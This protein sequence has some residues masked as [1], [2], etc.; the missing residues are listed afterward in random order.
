MEYNEMPRPQNPR[1]KPKSKFQ[2]FK[3][4]YLPLIIIALTLV[5]AV[6]FIIGGIKQRGDGPS[7]Q[8]PTAPTDLG[9]TAPSTSNSTDPVDPALLAE[10]E[11]LMQQAALLIPEYDYAGALAILDTFS[12]DRNTIPALQEVYAEYTARLADMVEWKGD[13]VQILSIH[14]LIADME[15]AFNDDIYAA[16]YRKNFIT[17]SEFSAILNQLYAN[18]Y[19]LVSLDD[20]YTMEYNPSSG[21]DVYVAKTLLLPPGKTPVLLAETNAN[22]Y[23]YMTDSNGNGKPDGNADGFAYKLCY[24]A[25]NGFYNEMINSEG[26]LVTGAFDIVPMLEDFIAQHP[27]FSYR[28]ARAIIACS[29]YD[30]ILGYR[31]NSTKLTEA[32][33]QVE[34][35]AV[36]EL[37]AQ[38]RATGYQIACFT[39][40]S[41]QKST[42]NYSELS[43][44]EVY[45]DIQRWKEVIEPVIGQVDIMLFPKEVDIAGQEIYD[46]AKFNV[47]YDAGFRFFLSANTTSWDQVHDK[48]VRHSVLMVTGS[49]LS[50]YSDRFT[51]L[52]DATTVLDPYRD[53]FV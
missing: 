26:K 51:A 13:Q 16:S 7:A 48:Y 41:T 45:A 21:R 17:T 3:E 34:R 35:A 1:R 11:E 2:I 44:N 36:A 43:N 32:E 33:K 25:E 9:T 42:L 24:D 27:D 31:I 23:T 12:G 52:F 28:N 18:G 6:M 53:S 15:R 47:L 40:G 20:L 8:Q 37:V 22:Y 10:A 14:L 38:L 30:G 19:I 5:L 46:N 49:Y 50:K 29:G 4:A 39:Y